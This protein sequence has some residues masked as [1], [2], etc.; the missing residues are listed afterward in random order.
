MIFVKSL[1]SN[2]SKSAVLQFLKA[3]VCKG[4]GYIF[5]QSV[6]YDLCMSV[7]FDFKY[8]MFAGDI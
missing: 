7:G 1:L 3:Y 6:V 4:L 2:G 5:V 8:Q